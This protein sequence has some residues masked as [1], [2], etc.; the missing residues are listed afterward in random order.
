MNSISFYHN[1]ECIKNFNK[2][3]AK[4]LR[5]YEYK[6]HPECPQECTKFMFRQKSIQYAD[7]NTE[8]KFEVKN[9]KK[10][11]TLVIN[12]SGVEILLNEQK[13]VY[14]MVN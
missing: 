8:P 7:L 5:D 9:D 11:A 2:C 6:P 10:L 1:F 4:R 12:L 14:P 13:E 3:V